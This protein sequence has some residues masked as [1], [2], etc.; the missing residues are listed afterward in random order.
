MVDR[1][2]VGGTLDSL[3]VEMTVN[4][5]DLISHAMVIARLVQPDGS[6]VIRSAWSA[7]LAWDDRLKLTHIAHQSELRRSI[8]PRDTEQD[9]L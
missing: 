8:D 3:G 9:D 5:G 4:A 7:G 1:E 2:Q 6:V